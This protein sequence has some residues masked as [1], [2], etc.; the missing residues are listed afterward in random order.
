[1]NWKLKVKRIRRQFEYYNERLL[2]LEGRRAAWQVAQLPVTTD[3]PRTGFRVFS[4]NEEDGI[5]QFLISHLEIRN[6]T[7]VEFG[8]ENYEE[9]NTRFLL[10]NNNWQ[11]MVM[12]GLEENIAYI[13]TDKDLWRWDLQARCAFVTT[14]NINALLS[15]SGFDEE[16]GLLSIDVDGND[17]WIWESIQS[18]RPHIVIVEYNSMFGLQPVSVPYDPA[19]DRT[20]AHFSK[21]YY[22]CSLSALQYLAERKGY[23]LIGSNLSGNNAF[24]VRD[25]IRGEVPKRQASDAYVYSHFRESRDQNGDMSYLRGEQRKSAIAHLPVV[26]V[27]TEEVKPLRSFFEPALSV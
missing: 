13:R 19:F 21:L 4:Q 7:F 1:M 5:I 17:Y 16:L 22:G 18:V 14:E 3:L 10:I 2:L 25:D 9:S 27:V 26:N 8:V 6:R 12:D 20:K 24:F 11:G 15:R 23:S